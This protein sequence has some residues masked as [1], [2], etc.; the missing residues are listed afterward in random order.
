[1]AASSVIRHIHYKPDLA[2]LSVWFAG[3]GRRYKFFDV[4][5]QLYEGFRDAPSRGRFFNEF[6]RGRFRSEFVSDPPG[7][8][9]YVEA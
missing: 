8:R 1:M 4:P 5:Q 3:S 6:I 9:R 2:E 7:R